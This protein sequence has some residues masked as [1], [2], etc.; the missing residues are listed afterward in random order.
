[1]KT[2]EYCKK[3]EERIAPHHNDPLH[4]ILAELGDVIPEPEQ[5][6]GLENMQMLSDG[7]DAKD[8]NLILTLNPPNNVS[9][10]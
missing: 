2:H 5:L 3:Y 8:H 7:R 6:L 9:Q 1:M 10:G 4:D